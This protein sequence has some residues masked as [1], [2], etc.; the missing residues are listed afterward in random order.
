MNSLHGIIA[1]TPAGL[2]DVKWEN[3]LK[4]KNKRKWWI[5]F[6]ILQGAYDSVGVYRGEFWG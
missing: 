6:T 5:P 1:S 2:S 4:S 3:G